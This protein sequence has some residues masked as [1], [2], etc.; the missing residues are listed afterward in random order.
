MPASRLTRSV[1]RHVRQTTPH[2][3]QVSRL[4]RE[5]EWYRYARWVMLSIVG[6]LLSGTIVFFVAFWLY[7]C[8]KTP[9]ES[10][11]AQ[12]TVPWDGYVGIYGY[13]FMVQIILLV[14]VLIFMFL[15]GFAQKRVMELE[16]EESEYEHERRRR[17]DQGRCL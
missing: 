5:F 7:I 13:L 12:G 2:A 6:L 11:E 8:I 9:D 15:M 4:R 1:L 10:L 17:Y 16:S 14:C 3:G